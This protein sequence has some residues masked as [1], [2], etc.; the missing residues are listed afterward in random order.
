MRQNE[1]KFTRRQRALFCVCRWTNSLHISERTFFSN[2]Q[3]IQTICTLLVT[4]FPLGLVP[5]DLII[6]VREHVRIFALSS[7]F[8]IS[9]HRERSAQLKGDHSESVY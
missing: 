3:S 4:H 7:L 2:E 9:Y 8:L 1:R 6:K 5:M